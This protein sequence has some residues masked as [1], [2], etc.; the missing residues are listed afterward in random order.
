MF[1]KEKME[2]DYV[3]MALLG[4]IERN[5]LENDMDSL[6]EALSKQVDV[7]VDRVREII[8]NGDALIVASALFKKRPKEHGLDWLCDSSEYPSAY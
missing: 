8:N 2:F 4:R 7:P 5:E 1:T 3:N 6:I